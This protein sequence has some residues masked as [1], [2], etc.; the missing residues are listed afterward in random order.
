MLH[1]EKD[2]S[3]AESRQS[4]NSNVLQHWVKN[5]GRIQTF[6]YNSTESFGP[7]ERIENKIQFYFLDFIV[8]KVHN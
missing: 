8:K 5:Q 2:V 7:K 3:I 1:K 6:F 4:F